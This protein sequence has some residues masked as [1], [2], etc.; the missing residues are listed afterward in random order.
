M[1]DKRGLRVIIIVQARMGSTRLPGKLFKEVLNKPLLAYL[2][3]RLNRVKRADAL[4]IATTVNPQDQKIVDFC[5]ANEIPYFRGSEEDVLN[6]YLKAS[7]GAAADIIVRVCSDCPLI[8]PAVVDEVINFYL[9]Y[10]P[11]YDYVSNTLTRTFPRGMDVE[12]FSFQSLKDA[13]QRAFYPEER[14]HVTLYFNRHQDS[15]KLGNVLY[16]HDESQH[17]WTLD[18]E[19]DFLLISKVLTAIYPGKPQFT[20]QDLLQLFQEHPEWA[21]INA[22]VQQK[23]VT[24]CSSSC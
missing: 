9:E 22:H 1:I 4:L 12:I 3:E 19:E 20:L 8:D 5:K 18:T 10:Y 7:C 13:A 23:K 6:R 21:Q 15:Y 2:T 11:L 24:D 17:R 14:E 16:K